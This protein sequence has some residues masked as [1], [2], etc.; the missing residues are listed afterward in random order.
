MFEEAVAAFRRATD[1]SGGTPMV[2]GQFGLTL[3]ESG[4]TAEARALL[5]RLGDAAVTTYV[6]PTSFAWIHLGLGEIDKFFLWMDRAI[7]ERDHM[8]T[9]VKSYPFLDPIRSDPRYFALLRR[10]NLEP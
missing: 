7:D 8:L 4:N 10:M 5:E 1:L 3:A 2:L 6:A 9:P